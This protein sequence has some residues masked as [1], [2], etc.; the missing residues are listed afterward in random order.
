MQGTTMGAIGGDTRSLDFGPDVLVVSCSIGC[1]FILSLLAIHP[2]NHLAE[3]FRRGINRESDMDPRSKRRAE[4]HKAH[5][6]AQ[7]CGICLG[8]PK[9]PKTL[10]P[11]KPCIL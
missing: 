9:T 4:P 11:H 10:K 5:P 8:I 1:F 7:I 3:G 2:A 6:N